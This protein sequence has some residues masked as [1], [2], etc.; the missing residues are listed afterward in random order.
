MNHDIIKEMT[1][2]FKK[3][4]LSSEEVAKIFRVCAELMGETLVISDNK[5]KNKMKTRFEIEQKYE[6]LNQRMA[7]KTNSMLPM[8]DPIIMSIDGQRWLIEWILGQ[9]DEDSKEHPKILEWK[10][11]GD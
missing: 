9:H 1:E 7:Q 4:N 8:M 5:T 11:I 3:H 2:I 10:K 6:E